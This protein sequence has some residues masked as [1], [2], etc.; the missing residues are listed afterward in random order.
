MELYIRIENGQP[1]DHP[2]LGDNFREA[3]PDVD[4]NNLPAMWARFTRIARPDIGPY[5]RMLEQPVYTVLEDGSV[6]DDWQ[7]TDLTPEE[8]QQKKDEAYANRPYPSWVLNEEHCM[9]EP[10]I[11]F[12][13]PEKRYVWDESTVSWLEREITE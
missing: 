4:T 8:I 9:A 1:K 11:P 6:T 10:P 2:I 5:K 12:P 7:I 13:D 3:F